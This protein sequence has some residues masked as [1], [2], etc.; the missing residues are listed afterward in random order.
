MLM[1][2]ELP[3]VGLSEDGILRGYMHDR[4]NARLM[5][6]AP[7]GN[8]RRRALLA[9]DAENDQHIHALR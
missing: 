6:D 8:G 2:R 5:G 9:L 3:Q 1:M 7:T 4:L